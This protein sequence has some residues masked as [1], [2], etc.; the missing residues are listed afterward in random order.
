MKSRLTLAIC[1]ATLAFTA[2]TAIAQTAPVAYIYVS[3]NYT[4]FYNHVVAYAASPNGQL[5]AVPGSPFADNVF[6]LAVNGK[7]L[8]GSDN[9]AGNDYRNIYSYLIQGNGSLKYFGARNIQNAP[10]SYQNNSCNQGTFLTFDHTGADL[11]S[12]VSNAACNAENA[13]QS[14]G[15]NPS[16]G[17][18]GYLGVSQAGEYV[19]APL[20]VLADNKYAYA[21]GCIF[22]VTQIN[23]Y[24]RQSNGALK[25]ISIA[26]P[27]PAGNPPTGF[28]QTCLAN[29]TADTTT[30]MAMNVY[31]NDGA[32]P[33]KIAT[34]SV[35]T[36]NGDLSTSSTYANMPTT[37]VFYVNT[38]NMAPSGKTL[39]VGGTGGLQLFNF[40]GTSQVTARTGLLT[41]API[42]QIHWDHA[43]HL[44]AISNAAS[45][46]YVF[47]VT[48]TGV[49]QAPGS[50]HTIPQPQALIVQP[51]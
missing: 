20:T 43:N 37:A 21:A 23:A 1:L 34:Y 7:Y 32:V 2:G 29:A 18:L 6:S 39:A 9:V 47:T 33:D 36:L 38:M 46:L 26:T 17:S 14:F 10:D 35:N 25:D 5:T 50:P 51:R 15:V 41:S 24:Q 12:Y 40:T 8:F 22:N 31:Y 48:S 30:H 11:Y 27:L 4:S 42:D 49:T 45:Q 44:Y 28:Y 19:P 16:T 13:Y 3:S